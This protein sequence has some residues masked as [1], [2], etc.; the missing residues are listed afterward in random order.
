[1]KGLALILL[2]GLFAVGCASITGRSAD[3]IYAIHFKTDPLDHNLREA[4]EQIE[5]TA[6]PA[7]VYRIDRLPYDWSA[8]ASAPLSF[9]VK[10]ELSDGHD[11]SAISDIHELNDV[12]FLRIASDAKADLKLEARI[13][14]TRGSE[15]AG[16][17][18][19]L[20]ANQLILD[21]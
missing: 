10:C 4:I 6:S 17:V 11:S 8:S 13:W 18:V 16:R 2:S 14:I 20:D 5:I 12:V 21:R 9:E 19:T 7:S 1:M 3:K 15:G